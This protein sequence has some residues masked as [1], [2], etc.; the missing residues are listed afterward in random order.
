MKEKILEILK[1]ETKGQNI[2]EINNKLH[3]RGMEEITELEDNLKEL[4]T[5]GILHMSKNREYMLMSNT[6]SLK[7]GK[8]RINKNGNGFVEC[9]PEDI[10][11]HSNDLN[12]A[13]NGDFVEVEIKTRLNDPEPEGYIRNVLKRDL[14]NV[15]GEMVKDKKTLAFKPDDEKLNI[16]VKLTK[17][18][19]KG[20]VEGHKVII[21]IIKEIGNRTFLGKVEKIIG[22]KNDP[23]VDILTI[24]AKHSIETEFSEDVKRELKN[25]PDEVCENDLI[26]RTDLTK[27]MIFTI[28]GDD[29]K[30]IDDAISVKR[31]GKNYVLGVHIADVSNYVKVGSALYDSAFSRGT[32][33]Y[34]A[35]TV[36]PMIPHQ[37]SNGICSLNPEVIRL[38]ISCVM[39]I[40]GNGKVISYDIFPSYIKSRKQMTYKNVNKILDENIIPEGYGEFADTLKL[41]HELSKIL[42]QEKINR[43]YIDFGIDEAK[44]I[45]DEN[46]KAIDIVKRVQ[47]TG[48]KL[49]E[50]FMIAAN[51][52]VAT[53]ISNM[54]LPFIY[55]VHD[56]PNAE[57]IEDFS[58]LI[59]QMGYQIHTNLNKITPVTMQKLLNEF[60]DKDEFVILSDMLLRS[61]KKAIYSTNNIGHFG[62]ASKNYTHFTSPIRRFPDLTVHRL[63]RT[64]LF[65]N[66]IDMETINFNAKYLIDVADHSSETEVNSVEAERDVL[67][68]KMAEYMESHIGEEYEG[69]ISGVTNFGMFVELDNLIEGLVHI[70]T[71]DGFYTY[72]PEMLSLISANKKNKYRI[73]DRVKIIVTNANKN[74][75]IIDF[76]LVKG[77]KNGNSK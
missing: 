37:L 43:G 57:K 4:V 60:R 48:E 21:S 66:R 12:G 20:C 68:M 15:V 77:E 27:E 41:M 2:N 44:V 29:T 51:E 67:D 1:E 32:S 30:D 50:D 39:T 49:I 52:T 33:S 9:E 10:F 56:L 70:S 58:N 16:A 38:T 23:G 18:S 14:K 31:D 45:Q 5:E 3:L 54:D 73:G 64:Y 62:L 69:I 40:D 76:E 55:R 22:H 7:V 11:V 6:K 42:R 71:L 59:K 35:D 53:H 46:G 28:D 8:L 75:G 13:I 74:Q 26:G 36:I 72:V 34:L 63:L 17:E 24:A 25:I 19:M 47:G 65:E 61:M